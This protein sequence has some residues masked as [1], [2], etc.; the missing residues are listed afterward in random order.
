MPMRLRR[1]CDRFGG[2]LSVYQCSLHDDCLPQTRY[3]RVVHTVYEWRVITVVI[4]FFWRTMA[5]WLYRY[6]Q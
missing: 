1:R 4:G 6:M 5:V 2:V 3:R